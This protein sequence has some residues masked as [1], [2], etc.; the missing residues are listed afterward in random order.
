[1]PIGGGAMFPLLA[2][3]L[4]GSGG[5][6]AYEPH[7]LDD[8]RDAAIAALGVEAD[9]AQVTLDTALRLGRCR[10]PLQAIASGSQMAQVRCDDTPGW[11][12]Y[13]PVRLRREAD[14]VVLIAA[15]RT[16]VPIT[17]NQLAVQ[18]RDVGPGGGGTFSDPD[19]LVGRIPNRG[20]AAGRAPAESDLAV[21]A[22]LRRGDPVVLVSRVG[23][24]EVRVPGRALGR[25]QAGGA[26]SVENV[27]SRRILRGK[28]VSEGVVEVSL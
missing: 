14:V 2:A 1:M 20:L 21:G 28:V 12:L 24:V 22:P 17:A 4:T 8:I 19:E 10:Q 11:Q 16:G 23:G 18:R 6:V 27:S 15:A 13:V 25:A 3:L 5:A 26:V 7:P 9:Q